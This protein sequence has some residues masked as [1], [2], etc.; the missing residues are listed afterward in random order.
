[1]KPLIFLCFFLLPFANSFSQDSIA[2]VEFD[3]HFELAEGYNNFSF[4]AEC[5][6]E[7]NAALKI[8][9]EQDWEVKEI[10]LNIFLA[11]V[12]RK[13]QDH[14]EG[15]SLLY[16]LH[17][18]INYPKLHVKKLGRMAA[19]INEMP[20]IIDLAR[21]R[22]SVLHYLD[23]ALRIATKLG[24]QSE[25]AGLYNELGFT[26]GA[27]DV[28]SSLWYL[29]KSAQLFNSIGD[30][31]NYVVVL[32]N[33]MRTHTLQGDY[34]K[35]EPIVVEILNLIQSS[36]WN[37][38]GVKLEFYRTLTFYY[39]TIGDSLKFTSWNVEKYKAKAEILETMNSSKLNSFRALYET[40]KYRKEASQG[41]EKLIIE[42]KRRKELI[43]YLTL[44]IILS[45]GVV[46]LLIR[47]RKLKR[48]V[49]K[50]NEK[51]HLL[52]VESNHRIKNNLQMIIS[53]LEYSSKD[54]TGKD[55]FALKR[56]SGKI[57]T[58][59]A[60]HKHL[61]LDVHNEKVDLKTYFDEII[62]LYQN[63]SN[64][65]FK[66]DTEINKISIPSE[67]IIYFGIIFNEMLS[68]TI[69][70]SVSLDRMVQI[71]VIDVEDC[72]QFTYQDNSSFEAT[73]NGGV[74]TNLIEQLVKRIEGF[75]F[76][77]ERKTGMY[78]FDFYA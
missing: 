59:S 51:Y 1:M 42:T 11:E 39:I 70:H 69:E 44:F 16:N 33:I 66:I 45:L 31:P 8:A 63:I 67:R 73:N 13:T 71:K 37:S 57:Q 10:S 7:V 17:N 76:K 55:S 56:I 14:A 64:N 20:G 68:N 32:T 41:V 23:S 65:R 25:Q 27:L 38:T 43:T 35:V 19:L 29:E 61:Y 62:S 52:I 2:I 3:K 78:Q 47:E 72:L 74:G 60:L 30:T 9:K 22:D 15:L 40:D 49:K 53:M 50:A 12:K 24:L 36:S 4:Y 21:N 34:E 54:V 58:I 46:F 6:D 77:I 48:A 28:D 18:S 5:M 26:I 75:N